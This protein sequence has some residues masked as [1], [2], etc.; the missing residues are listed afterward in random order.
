[1]V[2]IFSL[3]ML[4]NFLPYFTYYFICNIKT[5]TISMK[6]SIINLIYVYLKYNI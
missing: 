4:I 2:A 6:L 5:N 3:E 1:M